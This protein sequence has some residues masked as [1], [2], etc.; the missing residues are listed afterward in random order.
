MRLAWPALFRQRSS[1]SRATNWADDEA[2]LR[3]QLH[4]L[5]ADEAQG[6]RF[7]GR[8]ETTASAPMAP[9]LVPPKERTSTPAA[10]PKA[11]SST[12]RK[13]AAFDSRAPSRWSHIPRSVGP[14]GQGVDLVRP[15]AGPHLGGL[16]DRHH[17]GL[18]MV[19]V[20]DTIGRRLH[21]LGVSFPSGWPPG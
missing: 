1:V 10:D 5:L 20:A 19:L 15:I 4:R 11:P 8:N 6:G 21:Q 2:H 3:G 18:D 17:L 9:F 12:S 7:S 14:V 13:A 16:G